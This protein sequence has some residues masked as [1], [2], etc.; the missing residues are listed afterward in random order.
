MNSKVKGFT[1]L[2]ITIGIALFSILSVG[3]LQSILMTNVVVVESVELTDSIAKTS[4]LEK[5]LREDIYDILYP[6]D[7]TK[8]AIDSFGIEERVIT[9]GN[10]EFTEQKTDGIVNYAELKIVYTFENGKIIRKN[11]DTDTYDIIVMGVKSFNPQIVED[12]VKTL[13]VEI[14]NLKNNKK[15]IYIPICIDRWEWVKQ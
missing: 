14:V 4:N 11:L 1:L 13:V 5:V 15:T 12:K 2:E 7:H 10:I 3:I 9:N 6:M 8:D